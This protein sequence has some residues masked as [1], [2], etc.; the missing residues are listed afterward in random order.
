MSRSTALYSERPEPHSITEAGPPRAA[1]ICRRLCEALAGESIPGEL[2]AVF[3]HAANIETG[4]GL[5]SVLSQG[6]S[7]QPFSILLDTQSAFPA[8]GWERGMPLRMDASGIC[9]GS[10]AVL[11]DLSGAEPVELSLYE[12][13]KPRL[14]SCYPLFDTLLDWL[15]EHASGE[16]LAY[17]VT[18]R[19]R[20]AYTDFIGPR[21]K[22]LFDAIDGPD[23][24]RAAA[25]AARIAGCGPGLTPS[26]DDM[27]CG[28]MATLNAYAAGDMT[29]APTLALTQA[30][31]KAAAQKTN[32]ISA[33]FLKQ[34]GDGY[35]GEDLIRLLEAMCFGAKPSAVYEAAARLGGFGSTSGEDIL[36]GIVLAITYHKNEIIHIWRED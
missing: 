25:A 20:N 13:L 7:L 31:A 10:G 26:S 12:R 17:L 27:L 23:P 34:C 35:A 9:G 21:I 33:A 8:M 2:H 32:R 4:L 14:N 3:A 24:E 28:V 36:T 18:R 22:E 15:N 29:P 16:G 30:M 19:G 1:R 5:V 6:R 11:A